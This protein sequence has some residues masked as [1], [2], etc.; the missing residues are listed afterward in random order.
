VRAGAGDDL[1]AD[2]GDGLGVP[3]QR[4]PVVTGV[5]P[6]QPQR[7]E[8]VEQLDEQDLR[9]R[10]VTDG[11]RGDDQGQQPALRVDGDVPAAAGDLL[12]PVV[13]AGLPGDGVV[14]LDHLGVDDASRRLRGPALILPQQLPQPAHQLRR[15]TAAVP[16]L[17]ERVHRLPRGEIDRERP[18]LDA[19]LGHV[20]DG[21]AHRPQVMDHR[22]PDGDGQ[23]RHH[24]P[25]P[26]LQHLPLGI[27]QVRRIARPTVAAPAARRGA[28]GGEP[29]RDRVNRHAGPW[30][31]GRLRQPLS[32]QGPLHV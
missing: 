5:G 3:G 30:Q 16:P 13:T 21:V 25:R 1:D 32:Y 10:L 22:P 29:G 19:V 4:L 6:H 24:L 15:E 9:S 31:Y 12:A 27:G 17:E 26:G 14:G 2:R 20:R 23:L 11:R 18:P 28:R 8:R 7:G